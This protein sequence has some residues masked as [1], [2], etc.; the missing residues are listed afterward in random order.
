MTKFVGLE[1]VAI[2]GFAMVVVAA[3]KKTMKLEH[4]FS[5]IC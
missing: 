4:L 3:A 1:L 5:Y 2:S